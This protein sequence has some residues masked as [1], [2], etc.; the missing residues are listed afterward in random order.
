V[1][2]LWLLLLILGL[3]ACRE[4]SGPA[5]VQV[6]GVASPRLREGDFLE[7]R[8]SSFPEG[9]PAK[10]T[11]RGDL[12]RAGEPRQRNFELRLSGQSV[13]PHAVT[14][15]VSRQV[16][17]AF[18]GPASPAHATFHGS[19]EVSFS[20]RVA[21]T[22]PVT[23]QLADVTLDFVPAE[24]DREEVARRRAEGKRFAEFAGALLVDRGGALV[25]DGVMPKSRAERAGI[26]AGDRLVEL[27]GV[28]LLDLADL[29]P[30]PR[31][32]S[33]EL[34]IERAG[35]GE[36]GRVVLD[37][38]GFQPLSARDLGVTAGVIAAAVAFFLLCA[39]PLGR[40]LSFVEWRLIELFR[41]QR[42]ELVAGRRPLRALA[43]GVRP[44]LPASLA[45]YVVILAASA[46]ITAVSLGRGLVARELDLPIAV[47]AALVSLA[48]TSLLFGA[49]G[50][51]GFSARLRRVPLVMARGVPVAAALS[52]V[53]L[54]VESFGPD[55]L[56]LAQGPL[57]WHWLAFRGPLELGVVLAAVAALVPD[58]A[59]GRAPSEALEAP[60]TR[61]A[62]ASVT[63]LIAHIELI[64][65]SG[66]LAVAFFGG[67]RVTATPMLSLTFGVVLAGALVLLVKTWAIAGAVL[68]V[69]VLLGHVDL[70]E[71]SALLVR[72][73]LPVACLLFVAIWASSNVPFGPWL[74]GDTSL[75]LGCLLGCVSVGGVLAWRV[76][77]ALR[78][79]TGEPGLNPW[80]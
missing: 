77:H 80:I 30:P 3:S 11:L 76:V 45:E 7:L 71:S 70:V 32:R 59:R 49:P 46:L 37:V 55:D 67:A 28:R 18:S 66:V 74:G 9:R 33:A 40:V 25:V 72:A 38:D 56:A 68:G 53:V 35:S 65:V 17:R 29:V 64:V 24:G 20:P 60:A 73:V 63:R 75:A 47:A 69:R 8:G 43:R 50:D 23:G 42:A 48:V 15:E 10:V 39:S 26:I 21:G 5:L 61:A 58:P 13:S 19:V 44:S 4:A 16:E 6:T 27:A 34:M 79:R 52:V 62:R 2:V 41:V 54:R 1:R 31:A 57:P 36:R 78:H 14:V 22:A 51:R 12:N